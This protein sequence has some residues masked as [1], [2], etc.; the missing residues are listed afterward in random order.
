MFCK[1]CEQCCLLGSP[2]FD[3]PSLSQDYKPNLQTYN[4]NIKLASAIR[5][6]Q[7]GQRYF[8]WPKRTTSGQDRLNI[9]A[10]LQD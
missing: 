10:Q 2:A 5:R 1:C 4:A 7:V 6:K 3:E 8:P 9:L